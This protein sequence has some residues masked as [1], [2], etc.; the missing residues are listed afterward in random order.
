[1]NMENY[2]MLDLDNNC[3]HTVGAPIIVL[4][5]INYEIAF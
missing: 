5:D 2:N 1:M 4:V 3:A